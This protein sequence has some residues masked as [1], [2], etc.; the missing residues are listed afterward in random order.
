MQ[1]SVAPV[2]SSWFLLSLLCS[3]QAYGTREGHTRSCR[4]EAAEK[5]PI[6]VCLESLQVASERPSGR[7]LPLGK[8]PDDHPGERGVTLPRWAVVEA[9]PA[10]TNASMRRGEKKASTWSWTGPTTC[11][12]LSSP[13]GSAQRS[14]R[15]CPHSGS[16]QCHG[17][18]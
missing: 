10:E 4:K 1:L 18:S 16:C 2:S 13:P 11:C 5:I 3:R 14:P 6:L 15:I 8:Y 12:L 9:L 17:L 7:P